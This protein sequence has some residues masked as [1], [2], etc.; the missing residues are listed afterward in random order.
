MVNGQALAI[1]RVQRARD[2]ALDSSNTLDVAARQFYR[3][4][5]GV[6]VGGASL[7]ADGAYPPPYVE[8]TVADTLDLLFD[9]PGVPESMTLAA[10]S[11]MRV[12]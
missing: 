1:T 10:A 5:N 9:Y 2:D 6:E 12:R 3:C 4:P 11:Q 8:V 7:C